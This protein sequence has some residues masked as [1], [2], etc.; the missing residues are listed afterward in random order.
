MNSGSSNATGIATINNGS[1]VFDAL[2][3]SFAVEYK[4][5]AGL[6]KLVTSINGFEQNSTHYWFYY[7]NEKFGDAAADKYMLYNDSSVLFILTSEFLG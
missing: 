1:T 3:S 4:E 7:V 6:G 5:F 2:N